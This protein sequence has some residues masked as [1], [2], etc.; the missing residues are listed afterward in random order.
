VSP[1][2]QL[3]EKFSVEWERA[4]IDRQTFRELHQKSDVKAMIQAGGW[5]GLLFT[6][7]GL[8]LYSWTHQF[9]TFVTALFVI[10]YGIQANF[11]INGVHELGHGSVFETKFLNAVFVR[12]ISF[13]GWLHPDMFFSSHLRHH[14]YTLWFPEWDQENPLPMVITLMDFLT[15][16]FINVKGLLAAVSQTFLIATENIPTGHLGWSVSWE[17]T[18]YPPEQPQLRRPA[19][20]WAQVMLSG[21]LAITV[22]SI[23]FGYWLI[24][25]IFCLGP[26]YGGFLFFLC[27]NTQ[28]V[29]LRR[30]TTDF[31]LC[32]RSFNLH[33]A[34]RFLYW[35]M[36]YHA[37]HHM[38]ANVPCYN[39]DRLH[40]TIKHELPPTPNGIIE[41]WTIIIDILKKQDADK[42]YVQPISVQK[43][44]PLPAESSQ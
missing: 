7:A 32:C 23:L 35:Q 27:N 6:W 22:F 26:F 1:S 9:P 17:K 24:P 21:H 13:L 31:R 38:Y 2:Q 20:L 37:E 25:V 11:C 18:C 15:F 5:V 12:I 43:F 30:N 33:P 28:H 34:I 16:S 40:Q 4:K 14:R 36:N 8:A 19:T 39:L 44:A 3:D 41:V 10:M 29:G 42:T